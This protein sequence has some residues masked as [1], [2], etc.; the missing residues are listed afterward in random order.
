MK[1]S[2]LMRV[3]SVYCQWYK[4]LFAVWIFASFKRLNQVIRAH[5]VIFE[6]FL[7]LQSIERCQSTRSF[8]STT[9]NAIATCLDKIKTLHSLTLVLP[10]N[11]FDSI[12]YFCCFLCFIFVFVRRVASSTLLISFTMKHVITKIATTDELPLPLR[13][14]LFTVFSFRFYS[15][16]SIQ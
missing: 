13:F 11:Y 10:L 4:V 7:L 16:E 1:L 3:F 6:H 12:Q 5:H 9:S 15:L 8:P 2:F 14:R